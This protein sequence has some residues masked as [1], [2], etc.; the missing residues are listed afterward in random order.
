LKPGR[1][2]LEI[3]AGCLR[4]ARWLMARGVSVDV[5]EDKG[6]ITKYAKHYDDFQRTGGGVFD[7][8][9][10]NKRYDVIVSTF[11]LGVLTSKG[12]RLHLLRQARSRMKERGIFLLSVRG[13]GDV[14]T[15]TRK[16][17]PWRDGFVTSNGTFIKPFRRSELVCIVE[18][19]GLAV[20]P[21]VPQFASNSGVV[22]L[23]LVRES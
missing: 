5:T 20:H 6:T 9:W 19:A 7:E 22:D 8:T 16:G 14:K 3:G 17:R 4:N 11:V 2:T 13:P 21:L 12:S 1:A 15:K 23:I 10:P 18:C